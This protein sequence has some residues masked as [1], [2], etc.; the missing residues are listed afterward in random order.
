MYH[1]PY[2]IKTISLS[3]LLSFLVES[4]EKQDLIWNIINHLLF[5]FTYD[6]LLQQKM[7][8]RKEKKNKALNR[9]MIFST[10]HWKQ[11]NR[12][13]SFVLAMP[14]GKIPTLGKYAVSV[15]RRP[16]QK[17]PKMSFK[18]KIRIWPRLNEQMSF[19]SLERMSFNQ[20]SFFLLF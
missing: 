14:A 7:N 4:D 2:C 6:I 17:L 19:S 3:P 15:V 5:R 13:Y 16:L 20:Q 12:V 1:P 10:F 9:P 11:D 18:T 8:S